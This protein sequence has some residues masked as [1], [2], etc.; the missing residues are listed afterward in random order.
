MILD[1]LGGPHVCTRIPENT[2]PSPAEVRGDVMTDKSWRNRCYLA[3]FENGG[4]GSWVK[5][6]RW[7]PEAGEGKETGFT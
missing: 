2:E 4:G 1:Y 6:F 3:A 7:L 5:K